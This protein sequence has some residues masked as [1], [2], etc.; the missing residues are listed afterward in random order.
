MSVDLRVGSRLPVYCTSMGR[1]LLANLPPADLTACVSRI[2]LKP[3]TDRTITS[4]ERLGQ[5]LDNVRRAGYAIVDQELEIGLR[6]IAVPVTDAAGNVV[7]AMNV[8][9]Q[10]ARVTVRDMEAR[11]LPRLQ[12]AARELGLL[13]PA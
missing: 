7:A 11:F 9:A 5:V 4:R 1:V 3:F 10:A 13:L 6:S 12:A 2:E 8:S